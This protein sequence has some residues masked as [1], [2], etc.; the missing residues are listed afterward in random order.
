MPEF[1]LIL[2]WFLLFIG[3]VVFCWL[4]FELWFYSRPSWKDT[5]D[6]NGDGGL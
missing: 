5:E 1:S 6:D 4:C 3:V 2:V